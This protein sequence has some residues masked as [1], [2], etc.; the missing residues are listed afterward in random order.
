[1]GLVIL[2]SAASMLDTFFIHFSWC[3]WL[4]LPDLFCLT[5]SWTTTFNEQWTCS[6]YCALQTAFLLAC[7][8]SSA[9]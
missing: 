6:L 7:L 2:L 9:I 5:Q 1:M 8:K 4:T 3:H